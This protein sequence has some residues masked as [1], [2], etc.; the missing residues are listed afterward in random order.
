VALTPDQLKKLPPSVAALLQSQDQGDQQLPQATDAS[1]DVLSGL[2]GALGRRFG[3]LQDYDPTYGSTVQGLIGEVPTLQSQYEQSRQRL[4][5]DFTHTA[6]TLDQQNQQNRER[7]LNAMAD[8]GL[9]YSGANL[10]G[11]ER[12]GK[13]FQES[14]QGANTAYAR[15]QSDLST[16]EADA[17]KRIQQ[18]QAEAEAA[19]TGRATARDETRKWQQQQE[20]MATA[21]AAREQQAQEAALQQQQ[22]QQAAMDAQLAEV[23][24]QSLA[25]SQPMPTA[26]GTYAPPASGGGVAPAASPINTNSNVSFNYQEYNLRDPNEVKQLQY[27]LGLR[28]DGIMGPQTQ[29]A[30]Q[31]MNPVY[32]DDRPIDPST[33]IRMNRGSLYSYPGAQG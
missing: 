33:R 22:A 23:E 17:Y 1:T 12:I 15:G 2:Q 14:V 20:E 30:L 19:A 28:P 8:R 29:A 6:E 4:G 27:D 3:E 10:V 7:H 21:A 16:T 32:F 11:Q 25:A 24:R 9:G 31:A 13:Q 26:T 5:E 18:R